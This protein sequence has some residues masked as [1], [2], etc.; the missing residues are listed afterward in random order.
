MQAEPR[1]RAMLLAEIAELHAR[2]E[3]ANE[4]IRAIRN[5]EVDALVIESAKGMHVY[6]LQGVD[7]ASNRFRGEMLAQV[8]DAVIATDGDHRV[9]Y[10][11]A[12]AER[13]YGISASDVLGQISSKIYQPR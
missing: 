3:E 10:V 7:A 12:A 1:T 11:N 8:I 2:L 13:Q 9:T 4:T 5:G 6:T